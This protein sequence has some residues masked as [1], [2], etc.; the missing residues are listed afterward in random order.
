MQILD[1][2]DNLNSHLGLQYHLR[3]GYRFAV[4]SNG[5]LGEAVA[6]AA[7]FS[8]P[9]P[10]IHTAAVGFTT[11]ESG[12][13]GPL[14]PVYAYLGAPWFVVRSP[15]LIEVFRYQGS[16]VAEKVAE[17]STLG[18]NQAEWLRDT[19]LGAVTSPQFNL[20]TGGRDLLLQ[21]TRGALSSRIVALMG[22][23]KEE[24][25]VEDPEAFRVAI[26][27]LRRLSL[28]M[29]GHPK[30]SPELSEYAES[31]AER[32]K[33][34]FSFENIP[35]EAIAE[36]YEQFAVGPAI[37]RSK[38]VVY[39]PAWLARYL[40]SRLP[41]DAF[42]DCRAVDPTCGSG[43]FLVCYLE[44]LIEERTR[45][46][47]PITAAALS[48]AVAGIDIDPVAIE[49]ARL[50]LDFLGRSVG[51]TV[52]TWKLETKDATTDHF[53]G[54]WVIGNLPFG[55]RT[56][57]GTQDLSSVILANIGGADYK[58]RGIAL[59]LPDS[60]SYT[61]T[62][63]A[64]NA[65]SLLREEY[66]LQ[67]LTRL[68]ESVFATSHAQTLAVVARVGSSTR[69]VLV[70][71][72]S[73][74]DIPAFRTGVYASRTYITRFSDKVDDPWRFSPFNNVFERAE[75]LGRTLASVASVRM[76]LQ[77]YGSESEV[78]RS[79]TEQLGHPLLLEPDV[80]SRWKDNS[81]QS[82]KRLVAER[83]QV[84]RTGPWDGFDTPK[85]IVRATTV[86]GDRS[87]L[88]AIPD[89]QGIWFGDKFVGLWPILAPEE[90]MWPSIEIAI[91]ALAAYLQTRFASIWFDSNNPSRKLRIAVL[92]TMPIPYLPSLWWE[93]ASKL[94]TINSVI[95]PIQT[96][97]DLVVSHH[98]D[99]DAEWE[100]FNSAVESA[101]G[102]DLLT[103][104]NIASWLDEKNPGQM[105]T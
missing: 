59:I 42:R 3:R 28:N 23:V 91:T 67:E 15:Q 85:V 30:M 86:P 33:G 90:D 8:S 75:K 4:P 97:H 56:H 6:D 11:L 52:P 71:E 43:T 46:N 21:E 50:S 54:E 82:V 63:T 57:G 14:N 103:S 65:R 1:L 73:Q 27:V 5:G 104:G 17:V 12:R 39:T 87:R 34:T 62:S 9:I 100:W 40:V 70:R 58:R 80:F 10:S 81:I 36:M 2:A 29:N 78:I 22:L 79:H 35:P 25:H 20:F 61:Q 19:V 66:N 76:G 31:L 68:P 94:A 13:V 98:R 16:P 84:R 69:E 18:A 47:I 102:I 92:S 60:F 7:I 95:W 55:Y 41:S 48:E 32:L 24:K 93:R 37:R 101:L 26:R 74:Q 89:A 88:A 99:A 83:N 77:V 38:G 72:V 44:R 64:K 45:Y 105:R 49:A 53:E 51:V 96:S